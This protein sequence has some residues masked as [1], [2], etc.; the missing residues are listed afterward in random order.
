MQKHDGWRI[1]RTGFAIKQVESLH[2]R[3]SVEDSR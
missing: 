3:S 2:L 1:L